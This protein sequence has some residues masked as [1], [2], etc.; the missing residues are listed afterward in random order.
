[1][2]INEFASMITKIE[3]GKKNLSVAQVSEVLNLVNKKLWGI[4]YLL[5]RVKDSF[6]FEAIMLIVVM[7]C[8][9]IS[10]VSIFGVQ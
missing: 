9:V 10:L 6:F 7:V 2:K 1:M 8:A 4:P 3:G 5:I